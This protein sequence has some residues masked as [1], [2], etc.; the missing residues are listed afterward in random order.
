MVVSLQN[1]VRPRPRCLRSQLSRLCCIGCH[2]KTEPCD[3]TKYH[4]NYQVT[5][6]VTS[7][8]I[9]CP[10]Y[11][12][13]ISLLGL[14]TSYTIYTGYIFPRIIN[15]DYQLVQYL[16]SPT[17]CILYNVSPGLKLQTQPLRC[18]ISYLKIYLKD[19]C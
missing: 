12:Q 5:G 19:Q 3:V 14:S 8:N 13:V 11:T 15:Y 16:H 4:H 18:I 2:E 17:I 7:A 10:S 1:T 9:F 6:H